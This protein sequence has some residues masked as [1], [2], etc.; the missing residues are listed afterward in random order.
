VE[1]WWDI[2]PC[3]PLIHHPFH[4]PSCSSCSLLS[5]VVHSKVGPW[6]HSGPFSV[7]TMANILF[8]L[9]A[10]AHA[11]RICPDQH[12]P[13]S[14]THRRR[15]MMAHP[16]R[17]ISGFSHLGT[18]FSASFLT[19]RHL[20]IFHFLHISGKRTRTGGPAPTVCPTVKRVIFPLPTLSS[21][22]VDALFPRG[23]WEALL[24]VLSLFCSKGVRKEVKTVQN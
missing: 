20:R 14:E 15:A 19:F 17:I 23:G 16:Y 22:N 11:R 3:T 8:R 13:F 10:R 4:C 21:G 24:L 5:T 9:H 12:S 7:L 6:A 2:P 1:G 18:L